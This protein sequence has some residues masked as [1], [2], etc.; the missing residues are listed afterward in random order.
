MRS[1]YLWNPMVVVVHGWRQST[2]GLEQPAASSV[3]LA[4]AIAVI[5]LVTGI[6]FFKRREAVFADV[7]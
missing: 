1:V 6:Y 4:A 2:L 7:V 5:V 3:A